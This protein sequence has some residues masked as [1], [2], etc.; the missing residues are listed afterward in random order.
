MLKAEAEHGTEGQ[1]PFRLLWRRSLVRFLVA[2]RPP[3]LLCFL[4]AATNTSLPSALRSSLLIHRGIVSKSSQTEKQVVISVTCCLLPVPF[5][6]SNGF[7]K[8]MSC[9]FFGHLREEWEEKFSVA[10]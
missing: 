9:F 10:N 1:V 6:S 4:A 2:L 8:K 3:P 7:V 5:S